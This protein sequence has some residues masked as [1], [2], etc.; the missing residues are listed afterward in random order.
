[1]YFDPA[2][3]HIIYQAFAYLISH[4]KFYEYISI[5]KGLSSKDMF[6]F[7]ILLKFKNKI[8]NVTEKIISDKKEVSENRK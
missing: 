7:L 6:R 1:M 2:R 8:R 3:P 5:A 4:N